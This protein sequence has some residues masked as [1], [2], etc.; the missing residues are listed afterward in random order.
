MFHLEFESKLSKG[1]KIYLTI[2]L[3]S[4]IAFII[5]YSYFPDWVKQT[6]INSALYVLS[7]L[8]QSEAAVLGIVVTLSLV[9]IQL[10]SS[11]YSTRVIRLFKESP[12]LWILL[13][14]YII[15][16]IYGLGVLKFIIPSGNFSNNEFQIWIAYLLGIYAFSALIPYIIDIIN[17]MDPK[18]IIK[19]LSAKITKKNI[20]DTTSAEDPNFINYRPS[21]GPLQPLSDIMIRALMENDYGT[22]KDGLKSIENSMLRILKDEG[23]ESN[24]VT[25]EEGDISNHLFIHHI[26]RVGEIAIEKNDDSSSALIIESLSRLSMMGI[27]ENYSTFAEQAA[28]VLGEIGIK[29]ASK[30][31]EYVSSHAR[32]Y[33]GWVIGSAAAEAEFN[34]VVEIALLYELRVCLT[35]INKKLLEP[36]QFPLIEDNFDPELS[37]L[38][39]MLTTNKKIGYIA[40]S[41]KN[42]TILNSVIENL[43]EIKKTNSKLIYKKGFSEM[44]EMIN[45]LNS[46]YVQASQNLIS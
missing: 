18:I 19:R 25:D 41:Q 40:I 44:D 35:E 37:V 42:E 12:S 21:G 34:T 9:A 38:R 30:N 26:Q 24:E 13:L 5:C 36:T 2:F 3:V 27:D 8:V 32:V 17:F 6:N 28:Y 14:T 29:A 11:S 4:F 23:L 33:L 31:N 46:T 7:S 1:F 22:L 16:I 43:N 10:T 39:D 20:L 15:A 45:K